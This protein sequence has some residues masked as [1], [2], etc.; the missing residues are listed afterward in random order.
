MIA[1]RSVCGSAS[2]CL[3]TATPLNPSGTMLSF[4]GDIF[5]VVAAVGTCLNGGLPGSCVVCL[6][7]LWPFSLPPS[8]RVPLLCSQAGQLLVN[9]IEGFVSSVLS[10]QLGTGGRSDTGRASLTFAL[11][12]REVSLGRQ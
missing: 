1:G 7:L 6:P 11:L 8:S 4:N 2:L 3:E 10:H 5:S 12:G 9:V